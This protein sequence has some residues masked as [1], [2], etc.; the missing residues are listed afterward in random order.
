MKTPCLLVLS[1]V[2]EKEL[3]ARPQL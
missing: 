3:G 2:V 1:T